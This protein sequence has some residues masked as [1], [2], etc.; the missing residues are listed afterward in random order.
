[1]NGEPVKLDHLGPIILNVDGTISR[2]NNW[3]QMIERE[4]KM[5][6]R[7]IAKRNKERR[8]VLL[9]QEEEKK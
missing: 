4:Q 7:M 3:D 2:I 6:L 5:A 9:K 8:A 1:M